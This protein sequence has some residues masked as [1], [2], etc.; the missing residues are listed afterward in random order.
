MFLAA[1]HVSEV[2]S[3]RF[4]IRL[5]AAQ[6]RIKKTRLNRLIYMPKSRAKSSDLDA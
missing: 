3:W 6:K 2:F 1:F 4:L 5:F